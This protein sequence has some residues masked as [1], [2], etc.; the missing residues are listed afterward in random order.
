VSGLKQKL[1][2][3]HHFETRLMWNG[4]LADQQ[5]E[6]LANACAQDMM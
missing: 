3:P 2:E 6:S 1:A 4:K 5:L